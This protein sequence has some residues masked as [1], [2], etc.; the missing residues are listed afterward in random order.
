VASNQGEEGDE[1]D[2]EITALRAEVERLRL[3]V[4]EALPL[5]DD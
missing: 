2:D 5:A 4:G 1:P 3:L